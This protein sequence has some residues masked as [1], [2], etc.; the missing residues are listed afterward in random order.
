MSEQRSLDAFLGLVLL[1]FILIPLSALAE[2]GAAQLL[3]RWFV[4]VQY[5]AGPTMPAWYGLF[6]IAGIAHLGLR[7]KKLPEAEGYT[8]LVLF[9]FA[10]ALLTIGFM[11]AAATLVRVIVGW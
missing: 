1:F 4:A 11:L 3:W 10:H 9:Q 6:M 8:L 5:G 7:E 2:A